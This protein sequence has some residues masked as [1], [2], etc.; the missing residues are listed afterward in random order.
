[1]L[2]AVKHLSAPRCLLCFLSEMFR[3]AQHDIEMQRDFVHGAL[4]VSPDANEAMIPMPSTAPD[5]PLILTPPREPRRWHATVF[6]GYLVLAL[7]VTWPLAL[8]M[9]S[10][11]MQKYDIPVDAGQGIW[12]LWWARES[13]LRGW[14]PFISEHI[15]FPLRV[16]LFFQTLSLPNAL[17]VFP[18]L[19][20]L[21]PVVAFNSVALLSFALGGWLA[22]CVAR[23]LVG[24]FAALAGGFVFAFSAYHMQLLLVGAM[25]VIAIHWIPFY[26]LVLMRALRRPTLLRWLAAASALLLATLASSY[27]G[28]F[29]AVY[30]GA[31]VL[32]ALVPRSH[33]DTK[34]F[35]FV[36][37]CLR[38]LVLLYAVWAATLLL[39]TGA[40][41]AITASLMGDWRERQVF[42][43]AAL[44]DFL[45]PNT[46]HPLW[47]SW[48]TSALDAISPAG[49]E[50]GAA[51]GYTVYALLALAL[52]RAWR[53]AWPWALLALLCFLLALGPEL[54]LAKEPTG[55]PLPYALLNLLGPFRNSTRPNYFIGVLMIPVSVLV[56]VGYQA[57]FEMTRGKGIISEGL[58]PS[59]PPRSV[60]GPHASEGL[61]PSKPPRSVE[62]PHA[63]EGLR[64][65]KPPRSVEGP[66]ASE[67]RRP[68]KPPRSWLARRAGLAPA[69]V[70]ALLLFE[71]WPRP[72]PLLTLATSP[73]SAALT[74]DALAG[75]VL[76]LPPR[77][78]DS[79][80][81]LNQLCHGRPLAGGY[82]ARTPDYPP[83]NGASAFR[84]LWLADPEQ[85]DI[86][87]HAP[88]A[89]L[90]TLGMRFVVLNTEH[91]S[92]ARAERLRALLDAPG[93]TRVASEPA[94]VYAIDPA[95][96]RPVLRLGSGWYAAEGDGGRVWR[97]TSGDAE[98]F[99]LARA[100]AT[101]TL[102]FTA[103]ALAR[104]Q[105]LVLALDGLPLHT[106]TIPAAPASRLVQMRLLLPA[107]THRLALRS[108]AE[109]APDGRT[110]SLSI[111]P[112]LLDGNALPPQP[113]QR[114]VAVPPTLPRGPGLPCT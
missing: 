29:L 106:I 79:R 72:L 113:G 110:L 23:G 99:L 41:G 30:T 3:C 24:R 73:V 62:G 51:L 1:M 16:N 65:S 18:L 31:H 112:L 28:L 66:H 5:N 85:P 64:P 19:V 43:A 13:V 4:R 12:N 90:A 60:E 68:S 11:V 48:A 25:E 15:F 52:I 57:L 10:A 80:A 34:F 8:Q 33:E 105:D 96:A 78:N 108:D 86:L 83:I 98:L 44:V 82:L 97:W 55:V 74:T 39:Y 36:S 7:V 14:N 42:Q 102:S 89:E 91:M 58:R 61:R 40:P 32:L 69:F 20:A 100:P 37:S 54:K 21:G 81:M 93:I 9:Q 45:A 88:D 6:L 75:G 84:R 95:A 109:Q 92:G 94:E 76:D 49:V 87:A 22:Y 26:L 104:E 111:G 17:L 35:P 103:T 38:G 47:G 53:V 46:L 70:A 107:G 50:A 56:A 77:T 71:Y 2:N 101:V 67:G 63:S 114:V 59:K 27:Y